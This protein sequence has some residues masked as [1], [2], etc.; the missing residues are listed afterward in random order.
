[1]EKKGC[2]FSSDRFSYIGVNPINGLLTD[3]RTS[4]TS[5]RKG[6]L[7]RRGGA[8]DEDEKY[9]WKRKKDRESV[10]SRRESPE[11][12]Q[13]NAEGRWRGPQAAGF[14]VPRRLVRSRFV[15]M[16]NLNTWSRGTHASCVCYILQGGRTGQRIGTKG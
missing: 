5:A 13:T 6:W 12:R 15:W 14:G 2:S 7:R 11:N 3:A 4:P 1:M 9:R 8:R 10:V 16:E